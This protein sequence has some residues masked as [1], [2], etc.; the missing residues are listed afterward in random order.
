[1]TVASRPGRIDQWPA[2]S[3]SRRANVDGLSNLGQHSHST[4]P[5]ELTNAAEWQSDSSA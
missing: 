3:S 2:S 1:V 4:E 5:A